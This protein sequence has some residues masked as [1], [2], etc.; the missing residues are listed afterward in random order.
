MIVPVSDRYAMYPLAWAGMVALAAGAVLALFW[1]TIGLR[2]G[3]LL[4]AAAFG[5]T[6]MATEWRPLHLAL[7]PKRL[8]QMRARSM[9][10]REFGAGILAA[11]DKKEGLLFFAALA[12]HYVE[13]IASREVHARVGAE[14]WSRIV[15][16]FTTRAKSGNL[17]DA[18]ISAIEACAY[19][20]ETHFPPE[21]ADTHA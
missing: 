20:L 11:H 3:F 13:I 5:L 12:E 21:A 14:T 18:F 6:A 8:K 15:N 16:D 9:A 2:L 19:H 1:Q 4:E 17:A 10:H 7:V